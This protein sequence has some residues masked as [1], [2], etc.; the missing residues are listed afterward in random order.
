[1]RWRGPGGRDGKQ[2]ERSYDTEAEANDKRIEIESA[3]KKRVAVDPDLPETPLVKVFEKFIETGDRESITDYGLESSLRL[4]IKPF[5]ENR[6][7]GSIKQMDIKAWLKWMRTVKKYAESTIVN[8]YDNLASVFHFA[9]VND[10]IP[11]NPCAGLKVGRNSAKRKSKKKI[12]IPTLEEIRTI[13]DQLPPQYQLIPWL[14]CGLG[15]R[16]GEAMAITAGQFDFEAGVVYIDR[17]ITQDGENQEPTT[18]RLIAAT[19]GKGRA[20]QIRHLKWRDKDEGR[21]VP[22]PTYVADKA[23]AH[24]QNFGTYRIEEGPNRMEGDYLFSNV[25][26]TNI[27]MYSLAARLWNEAKKAAGITRKITFQ[28]LR[29]FFA[30][31]ALSRGVPVNEAAAWLGHR[32]PKVTYLTYAHIMPD[33]PKRLRTVM[34]SIFRGAVAMDLPLEFDAMDDG[35]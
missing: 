25:G 10:Y 34:D 5:F 19:K 14:L 21:P 27:M 22:M 35:A 1:V 26:R 29:H 8:R 9:W 23:K 16:I 33:A 13:A 3:L 18:A 31:A 24:I 6:P 32:D 17:Q 4:H 12:Q 7:I 15:L 11:K 2:I 30:S 20:H 28:W